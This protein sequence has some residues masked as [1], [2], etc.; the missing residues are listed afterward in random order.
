MRWGKEGSD[1][2][3]MTAPSLKPPPLGTHTV[4]GLVL[5]VGRALWFHGRLGGA[6]EQSSCSLSAFLD[7]KPPTRYLSPQQLCLTHT[8]QHSHPSISVTP[9]MKQCDN[10]S[11][12]LT[13]SAEVFTFEN[14]KSGLILYICNLVGQNIRKTSREFKFFQFVEKI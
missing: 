2:T 6:I 1:L 13:V 3:C 4:T 10:L 11:K 8:F 9:A 5:V 12:H 7:Y 14:V